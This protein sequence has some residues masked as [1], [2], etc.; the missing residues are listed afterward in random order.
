MV[1]LGPGS[2]F[3]PPH[4]YGDTEIRFSPG[5]PPWSLQGGGKEHCVGAKLNGTPPRDVSPTAASTA[6]HNCGGKAELFRVD[7][8]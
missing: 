7:F 8:Y 3:S 1:H 4:P 6:Q 2:H 5:I